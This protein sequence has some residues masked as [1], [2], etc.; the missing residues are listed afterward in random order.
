MSISE[1]GSGPCIAYRT[2][3]F[4]PQDVCWREQQ[5]DALQDFQRKA[6]KRYR[7]H[8]QS[9]VRGVGESCSKIYV[10]ASAQRSACTARPIEL[11]RRPRSH[12]STH[13]K[14]IHIF[15]RASHV[16]RLHPAVLGKAREK[17]LQRAFHGGVDHTVAVLVDPGQVHTH[18]R[19]LIFIDLSLIEGFSGIYTGM[20]FA[21]FTAGPRICLRI[22]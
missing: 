22:Q 18:H 3:L 10:P 15:L 4:H 20:L 11:P 1:K 19:Y 14:N 2:D 21:L 8:C 16:R 9:D 12:R 17:R 7:I 13:V 5:Q 6:R